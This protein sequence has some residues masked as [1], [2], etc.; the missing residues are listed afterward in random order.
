MPDPDVLRRRNALWQIL[1]TETPGTPAFD[2]AF[3]ALCDL[4][5]WSAR[6]VLAGLGVPD[7]RPSQVAE[8]P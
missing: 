1:R 6:R 2:A 8:R 7:D 3:V 5:G 4:T